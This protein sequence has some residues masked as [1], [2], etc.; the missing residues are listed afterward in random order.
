[1]RSHESTESL[2]S[3][4]CLGVIVSTL[5]GGTYLSK[6]D[7]ISRRFLNRGFVSRRQQVAARN[8]IGSP[9][10]QQGVPPGALGA[11]QA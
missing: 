9:K 1:M 7:M 2:A 11:D 5:N 4:G 8:S 3:G 10:A 6:D